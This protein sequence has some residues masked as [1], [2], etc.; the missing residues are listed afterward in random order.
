M[1]FLCTLTTLE[2]KRQ[3]IRPLSCRN[4]VLRYN[5]HHIRTRSPHRRTATTKIN[6]FK[7]QNSQC[8]IQN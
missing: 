5:T 2:Q 7:Y 8:T 6:Q 1:I 3:Q 4:G